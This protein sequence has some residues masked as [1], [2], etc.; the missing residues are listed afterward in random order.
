MQDGGR[1]F[2]FSGLLWLTISAAFFIIAGSYTAVWEFL[3]FTGV[4]RDEL[5]YLLLRDEAAGKAG[6]SIGLRVL[7]DFQCRGM[8]CY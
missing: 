2:G 8:C 6:I 7:L 1:V 3:A 4:S 5:W